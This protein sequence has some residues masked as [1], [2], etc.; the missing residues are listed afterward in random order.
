[1]TTDPVKD[2]SIKLEYIVEATGTS[3]D[4]QALVEKIDDAAFGA[5]D[6]HCGGECCP[7]ERGPHYVSGAYGSSTFNEGPYEWDEE[8]K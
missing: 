3:A 1:M 7:L 5:M 8:A 4:M 2:Y 6:I